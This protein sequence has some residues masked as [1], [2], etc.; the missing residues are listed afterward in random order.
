MD[1]LPTKLPCP[2]KLLRDLKLDKGVSILIDIQKMHIRLSDARIDVS[3]PFAL[4]RDFGL[5][6]PLC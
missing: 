6:K 4:I 3:I 2:V 1:K 5:V